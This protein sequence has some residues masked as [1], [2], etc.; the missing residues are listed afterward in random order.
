MTTTGYG[1]VYPVT[2]FGR[3]CAIIMMIGG[4][5]WN[6]MPL[7]LVGGEFYSIYS[8]KETEKRLKVGPYFDDIW[9]DVSLTG[10]PPVTS[11]YHQEMRKNRKSLWLDSKNARLWNQYSESTLCLQKIN[12]LVEG[13]PLKWLPLSAASTLTSICLQKYLMKTEVAGRRNP[14]E[15]KWNRMS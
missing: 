12:T 3:L 10:F 2:R 14:K 1:E 11:C 5:A 7:S 15:R 9:W 13:K 6:S 8:E 4:S